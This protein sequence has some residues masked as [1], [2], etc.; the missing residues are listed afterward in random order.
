MHPA[1]AAPRKRHSGRPV[2]AGCNT[3]LHGCRAAAVSRDF[4]RT[5]R[6]AACAGALGT[7]LPFSP[8]PASNVRHEF[9]FVR[10]LTRV[11][12]SLCCVLLYSDLLK[13]MLQKDPDSRA[14]LADVFRH[15]WVTARG[16]D[17]LPITI[18]AS[19]VHSPEMPE[20]PRSPLPGL[21]VN[22]RLTEPS[23]KAESS[24]GSTVLHCRDTASL[25]GEDIEL[26]K[27]DAGLKSPLYLRDVRTVNA[28]PHSLLLRRHAHCSTLPT[29]EG[30][31]PRSG[32]SDSAGAFSVESR[33]SSVAPV[34]ATHVLPLHLTKDDCNVEGLSEPRPEQPPA[35]V[36]VIGISV[37]LL[38]RISHSASAARILVGYNDGDVLTPA[39]MTTPRDDDNGHPCGTA[40]ELG[41]S[42]SFGTAAHAPKTASAAASLHVLAGQAPDLSQ[43][44]SE[45]LNTLSLWE[46]EP[47]LPP[48]VNAAL[49]TAAELDIGVAPSSPLSP[50][51]GA[52]TPRA[53]WPSRP[54]QIGIPSDLS[55][56]TSSGCAPFLRA[57]GSSPSGAT[58]EF[59][60]LSVRVVD[61]LLL[62]AVAR[63]ELGRGAIAA[64][65]EALFD[66]WTRPPD[67]DAPEMN[68]PPDCVSDAP[69]AGLDIGLLSRSASLARYI[70]TT[71]TA[72]TNVT[73]SV[74]PDSAVSGIS[75]LSTCLVETLE[76]EDLDA[77]LDMQVRVS[78]A[79]TLLTAHARNTHYFVFSAVASAHR[80]RVGAPR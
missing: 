15:P 58:N 25:R 60:T 49:C 52:S 17:P 35:C 51:P 65:A 74:R 28:A 70:T 37:G 47:L 6:F 59:P 69:D 40:A 38:G 16:T 55:V 7:R 1:E 2:V 53:W 4:S 18:H 30:C 78:I 21:Q 71:T 34:T 62:Q 63:Q 13:G 36:P 14:T 66:D 39:D 64:A 80:S 26:E 67:E 9:D 11:C 44:L 54:T 5:T 56:I 48:R 50:Q 8:S 42:A 43:E 23:L 61:K 79:R 19:V 33:L 31:L 68:W 41:G 22:S 57:G 75:D 73:T 32:S 29:R 72:T 3:L 77:E 46:M 10:R 45:M 76:P 20:A 12:A 27:A 24:E